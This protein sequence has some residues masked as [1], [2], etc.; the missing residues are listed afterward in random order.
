MELVAFEGCFSRDGSSEHVV[1]V[2]AFRSVCDPEE[3]ECNTHSMTESCCYKSVIGHLQ[4]DFPFSLGPRC[5]RLPFL[6]THSAYTATGCNSTCAQ[7]L[8]IPVGTK[9]NSQ[10]SCG[11]PCHQSQANHPTN[12]PTPRPSHCKPE[13]LKENPSVE[14]YPASNTSSLIRTK[15]HATSRFSE[16][17]MIMPKGTELCRSNC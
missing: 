5:L 3:T 8:G 4:S 10:K 14:P 9:K 13:A 7:L 15:F 2:F 16:G 6:Q 12:T 1:R 11:T 17:S